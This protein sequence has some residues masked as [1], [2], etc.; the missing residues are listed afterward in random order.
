MGKNLYTV[1]INSLY[2]KQWGPLNILKF[3]NEPLKCVILCAGNG[4]RILPFSSEK[5]KV[6]IKINEKPILG[7]VIDYWKEYT[8]D[9][10]FVVG[11]KKDQIINYVK[12]LPI[13]AEFIEQKKLNGIADALL[14]V[15][16]NVPE[17]FIVALGDCL[18][19]G[20]FKTPNNPE[21]CV[22]VYKTN[23]VEEIKLNYSIEINKDNYISKVIEKP[24]NIVNNLCGMGVYIFK[25]SVFDYITRTKPSDLRNEIEITDV[26]QTM[27]DAGEK[28]TPAFLNGR[29]LN[30]TYPEDLQKAEHLFN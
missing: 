28:I 30:V 4:E 9:F 8:K 10:V 11:Y 14:H 12:K 5:T 22:G 26:I 20:E 25:R 6:M 18:Y 2:Y 16:N 17:R 24:N 13:N 27:I 29:Y 23:N 3:N 21:Q 1:Y 19:Y 15:Q 7:Y